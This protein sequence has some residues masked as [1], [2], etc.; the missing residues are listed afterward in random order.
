M[1]G[2]RTTAPSGIPGWVPTG[3][4]GAGTSDLRGSAFLAIGPSVPRVAACKGM[5]ERAGNRVGAPVM[6]V[7]ASLTVGEGGAVGSSGICSAIGC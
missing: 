5:A 6:P 2:W 3:N 7:H 1:T 4:T